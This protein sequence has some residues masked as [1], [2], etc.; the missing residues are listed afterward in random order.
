MAFLRWSV[1]VLI[2]FLRPV[3]QASLVIGIAARALGVVGYPISAMV[4]PGLLC[5]APQ[6]A[7]GARDFYGSWR[8][9]NA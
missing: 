8:H 3:G 5:L 2:T 4:L 7:L 1:G 9:R 6:L